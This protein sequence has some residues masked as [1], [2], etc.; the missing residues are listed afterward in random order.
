MNRIC[1]FLGTIVLLFVLIMTPA[2]GYAEGDASESSAEILKSLLQD[3]DDAIEDGDQRMVAHPK[4]IK[5][6]RSLV[7]RY[8]AKLRE[9]FLYDDFS[10]GD[11]THYPVWTVRSGSF[12]VTAD[13]RLRSQVIA[14]RPP[15]RERPEEQSG[16]KEEALNLILKGI[17]EATS[18]RKDSQGPPSEKNRDT[19]LRAAVIETSVP[20]ASAFEVDISLVAE[21]DWGSMEIVLQGGDP[22]QPRYRLVYQASPSQV[23]P[24]E[25]I[26]DSEGR[27]YVIQ[28]ASKYPVLEDGI[29]HRLQWIRGINGDMMV[30]V[31]GK[32][33]LSTVE[34]YYRDQFSGLAL[35]NRG[36]TYE[37]DS[38]KVL[39]PPKK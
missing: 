36:G 8:Q 7:Q 29:K 23:R 25:V 34:L 26:R 5:K 17:L 27:R 28:A 38:I 1:S 31:D 10:D 4:F 32:T 30:M 12:A 24:M 35:I 37:W 2:L 6:L 21:A 19:N 15:V 13:H 18:D 33:V 9:V 39:Q 11:Y 3:L 16:A 22:A 20:I 14:N